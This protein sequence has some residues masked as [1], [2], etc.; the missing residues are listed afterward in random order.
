[1]HVELEDMM[2]GT[3]VGK[4]DTGY[5]TGIAPTALIREDE[6]CFT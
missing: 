5:K 4:T 2:C 3:I 6:D 1:M